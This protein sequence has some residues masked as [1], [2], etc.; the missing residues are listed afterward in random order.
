MCRIDAKPTR[1]EW[2]AMTC[3]CARAQTPQHEIH[4]AQ[5]HSIAACC[6]AAESM[7]PQVGSHC[8]VHTA[9]KRSTVCG[10]R[11]ARELTTTSVA[12]TTAKLSSAAPA[13]CLGRRSGTRHAI[14]LPTPLGDAL[15][16]MARPTNTPPR[17]NKVRQRRQWPK[18]SRALASKTSDGRLTV[19]CARTSARAFLF[20]SLSSCLFSLGHNNHDSAK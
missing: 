19:R 13:N 4:A 17:P 7:P 3:A 9:T 8:T 18:S 16:R 14:I 20:P 5:P 11:R 15:S 10:N 6:Q 2:D 1:R 12:V